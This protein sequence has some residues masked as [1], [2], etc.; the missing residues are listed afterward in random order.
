MNATTN[1]SN[2]S[3][4]SDAQVAANRANAK[5]ST[6]PKS[7][8]AK[9]RTRMNATRHGLTGQVICLSEEDMEAFMTFC[10]AIR[11]DYQPEGALE[12]QLAQSI[13]EDMWRL[14]RGRAW[15]TNTLAFGCFNGA[16]DKIDCD[17]PQLHD[18]MTHTVVVERQG[19]TFA[20]VALYET[21]LNRNIAKNEE[22]LKARQAERK[23]ALAEA[24][25]EA[26]LLEEY[27]DPAESTETTAETT[28]AKPAKVICAGFVF[29]TQEID[30]VIA[31]ARR[32]EAA[33]HRYCMSFGAA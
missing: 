4:I 18:A 1:I 11:K 14:N 8:E 12:T 15:E 16:G 24:V 25:K 3:C 23:V 6:G 20:N 27:P 17:I 7:P 10:A 2:L 28:E 26:R 9:Q 29:S 5:R 32:L 22:R 21:R 33:R 13:A 31:R 30:R 19:K